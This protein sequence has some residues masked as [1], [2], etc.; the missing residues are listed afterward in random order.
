MPPGASDASPDQ[1]ASSESGN[2][3]IRPDRPGGDPQRPFEPISDTGLA[4]RWRSTDQA[5]PSM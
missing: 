1:R 5:P 3:R 2:T 4:G